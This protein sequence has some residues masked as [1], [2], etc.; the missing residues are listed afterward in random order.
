V[1]GVSSEKEGKECAAWQA[2]VLVVGGMV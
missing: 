2:A 1:A